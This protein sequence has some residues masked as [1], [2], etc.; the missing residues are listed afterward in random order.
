MGKAQSK[1]SVDITT[2]TKGTVE[3]GTG[4]LGKL[5]D[6]DEIKKLNGDTNHSEASNL[7][8]STHFNCILSS[9]YKQKIIRD[10]NYIIDQIH[11]Y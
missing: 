5:E 7:T 4:K 11:Q 1:R 8:V 9:W 2:E 10:L 3:E 6:V